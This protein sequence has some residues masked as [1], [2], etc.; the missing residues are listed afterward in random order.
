MAL[1]NALLAVGTGSRPASFTEFSAAIDPS[2]V[3]AALTTTQKVSIRR[4]K[5]PAEFVV[6]LVIGMALFRDHAI[7]AVVRHLDLVLPG[8]GGARGH[9]TPGAL[10]RARTRL[11]AA[12]LAAFRSRFGLDADHH[13]A[14]PI[15]GPGRK[16]NGASSTCAGRGDLV[17]G[18]QVGLRVLREG[19]DRCDDGHF[20]RGRNSE[21]FTSDSLGSVRRCVRPATG[22][23]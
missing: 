3:T 9:V 21:K 22:T 4:R 11:G 17:R 16:L 18:S 7:A 10:V 23:E 1:G 8:R 20:P 13:V 12:P 19:G 2:W 14:G 5:L 6:W 15:G